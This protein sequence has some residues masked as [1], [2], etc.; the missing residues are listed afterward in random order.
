MKVNID[1]AIFEAT[2]SV[3]LSSVVRDEA[4]AF[5]RAR[6]HRTNAK[7]QSREAEAL[8]LKEALSWMKD[9]SFKSCMFETDAKL[10]ADACKGVQGRSFFHKIVLD[11]IAL[12]KH[13]YNV[14]VRFVHR[15]ANGVAHCL[16]RAAHSV[17]DVQEWISVAPD[18]IHDVLILDS[19]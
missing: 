19:V 12:F 18:I 11:C 4:G 15:S 14:L 8:S 3:G 6:V 2:G 5:I 16:A 13:F 1:A 10:L 7:L 9:L 17:S